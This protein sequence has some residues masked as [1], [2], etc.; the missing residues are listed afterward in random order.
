LTS[1]SARPTPIPS[2]LGVRREQSSRNWRAGAGAIE[3]PLYEHIGSCSPCYQEWR[4]LQAA[5][6]QTFAAILANGP[7]IARW[8]AAAV[9]VALA[10]G[11]NAL[12]A[13]ESTAP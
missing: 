10:L 12:V 1:Y 3:D 13:Q 9:V 5:Q 6:S 11:G 7:T 2:E 4:A 8:F